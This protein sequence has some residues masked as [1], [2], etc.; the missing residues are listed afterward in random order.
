MLLNE[1]V[2]CFKLLTLS[3]SLIQF[4]RPLCYSPPLSSPS[5]PP[6]VFFL[7]HRSLSVSSRFS[8]S[9]GLLRTSLSLSLDP[10]P[11]LP[12]RLPV[13]LRGVCEGRPNHPLTRV[14]LSPE[15]GPLRLRWDKPRAWPSLGLT[16]HSGATSIVQLFHDQQVRWDGMGWDGMGWDEVKDGHERTVLSERGFSSAMLVWSVTQAIRGMHLI[17]SPPHV[18][19]ELLVTA[20]IMPLSYFYAI[21]QVGSGVVYMCLDAQQRLVVRL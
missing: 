12:L 19:M 11:L 2:D 17:L 10:S 7:Q 13:R 15:V 9:T 20:Q 6:R 4:H 3:S 5:H 16:L 8:S 21:T 1:R 18:A 14:S